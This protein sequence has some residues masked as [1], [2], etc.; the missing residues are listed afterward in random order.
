[1]GEK[2]ALTLSAPVTYLRQTIWPAGLSA[3]YPTNASVSW[4]ELCLGAALLAAIAGVCVA[5]FLRRRS[6]VLSLLAFAVAWGYVSLLPMLGIVKVGD[7]PH[8]DRY[9]YWVGC[10]LAAVAAMAVCRYAGKFEKQAMR[11]QAGVL[12]ALVLAT[13]MRM[14]VWKD[15]FS[16]YA[17]AA[18]KSWAAQPVCVLSRYLRMRGED[19]ERQAEAMLR[20]ALTQTHYREIRAE[21]AHLLACRARKSGFGLGDGEPAFEEARYEAESVLA[22]NPA[23]ALANEALAIVEMKEGKWASAARRLE[24]ARATSDDPSRVD[25][26]L[27]VCRERLSAGKKESDVQR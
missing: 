19:G 8:S 13:W 14:P 23:H 20:T 6:P 26:E 11:V 17:D 24:V 27:A 12:G 22:A 21:F 15:A 18:P 1:M 10:G 25:G 2:V 5:W 16:L 3:F 7:Q 4:I 9:T